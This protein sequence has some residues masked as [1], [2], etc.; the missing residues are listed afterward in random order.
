MRQMQPMAWD[1]HYRH[2]GV[3]GYRLVSVFAVAIKRACELL[4]QGADVTKVA[5]GD[6]TRTIGA[7]EIRQI[8]ANERVRKPG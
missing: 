3:A 7:D 4:D 5:N 8:C 1:I 6:G 2:R